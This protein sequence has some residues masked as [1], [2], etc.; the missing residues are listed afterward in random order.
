MRMGGCVPGGRLRRQYT[1]ALVAAVIALVMACS[2]GNP[3]AEPPCRLAVEPAGTQIDGERLR[4][5]FDVEL[6]G[7][8]ARIVYFEY[9]IRY[10][11]AQGSVLVDWGV[12]R[13]V[14]QPGRR[15]IIRQDPSPGRPAAV[16]SVKVESSRCSGG[17]ARA[18]RHGA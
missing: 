14:V 3:A 16:L 1:V 13:G 2:R 17:R 18:P 15:R 8:I 10:R 5:A 11:D 9:S 7:R 12:F 6:A 4:S